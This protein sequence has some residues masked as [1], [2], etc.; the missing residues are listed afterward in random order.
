MRYQRSIEAA[1]QH[2]WHS[3]SGNAPGPVSRTATSNAASAIR[4]RMSREDSAFAMH[5]GYRD[6]IKRVSKRDKAQYFS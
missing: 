3:K 2:V 4:E 5:P 1:A 6:A